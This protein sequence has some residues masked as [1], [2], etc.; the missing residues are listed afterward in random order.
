MGLELD[1]V[2]YDE[3]AT[4][5]GADATAVAYVETVDGEGTPRWGV[6]VHP[7]IITASLQAVAGAVERTRRPPE[8]RPRPGR[9]STVELLSERLT[10]A[11]P[12]GLPRHRGT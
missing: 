2:D 10:T 9:P 4:G 7:N 11:A 3:H 12:T 5:S 1:V 6:G 8:G